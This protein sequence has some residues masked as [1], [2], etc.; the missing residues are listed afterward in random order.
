MGNCCASVPEE[1][2]HTISRKDGA[3]KVGDAREG[4]QNVEWQGEESVEQRP[5]KGFANASTVEEFS[6]PTV[7]EIAHKLGV[8]EYGTT[9]DD[10]VT[11]ERKGL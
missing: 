10:G 1:H 7:N 5:S 2:E 11:R 4:G 3:V 9:P 6:N 8:F